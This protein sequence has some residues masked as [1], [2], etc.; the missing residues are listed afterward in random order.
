MASNE[1]L[2]EPTVPQPPSSTATFTEEEE[3]P[4]ESSEFDQPEVSISKELSDHIIEKQSMQFVVPGRIIHLILKNGR[5]FFSI[6]L[7]SQ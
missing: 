3:L 1:E 2:E 4:T 6:F 7:Y 5:H